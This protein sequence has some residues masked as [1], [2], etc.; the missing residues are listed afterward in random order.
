MSALTKCTCS[1]L[2]IFELKNFQGLPLIYFKDLLD[3]VCSYYD[4]IIIEA[5]VK[6][7]KTTE[8]IV[9]KSFLL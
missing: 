2:E 9:P 8:F 3:Y 4:K 1:W 7:A 6:S 5:G